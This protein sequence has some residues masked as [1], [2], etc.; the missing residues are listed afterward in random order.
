M[1]TTFP[2]SPIQSNSIIAWGFWLSSRNLPSAVVTAVAY[3]TRYPLVSML[4]SALEKNLVP[5][6]CRPRNQHLIVNS[7]TDPIVTMIAAIDIKSHSNVNRRGP[8]RIFPL[9]KALPIER[10]GVTRGSFWWNH[11]NKTYSSDI[12]DQIKT[13]CAVCW[14]GTL[15]NCEKNRMPRK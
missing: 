6:F 4:F 15:R 8:I 1:P 2:N 10:V 5:V 7:L 3:E 14:K 12:W 11:T 9:T 13:L